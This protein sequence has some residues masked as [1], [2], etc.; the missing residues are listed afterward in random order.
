M[1]GASQLDRL[2]NLALEVGDLQKKFE[3]IKNEKVKK[4]NSTI[5]G[6]KLIQPL[7]VLSEEEFKTG[8]TTSP[9]EPEKIKKLL[10]TLQF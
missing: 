6:D 4:I 8:T 1:P 9:V 7:K 5:A 2:A 10:Q 3:A